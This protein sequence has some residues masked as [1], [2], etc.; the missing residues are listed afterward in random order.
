MQTLQHPGFSSLVNSHSF[1]KAERSGGAATTNCPRQTLIFASANTLGRSTA[2][3]TQHHSF[4]IPLLTGPLAGFEEASKGN[5]NIINKYQFY[6]RFTNSL[7]V[8]LT[9]LN[10]YII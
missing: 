7:Y 3:L 4:P 2:V 9:Y 10:S 5:Y 1:R 8:S 6:P